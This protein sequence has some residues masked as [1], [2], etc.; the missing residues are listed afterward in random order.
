MSSTGSCDI[1]NRPLALAGYL[2]EV[3]NLLLDDGVAA[4]YNWGNHATCNCGFLTRVIT[5]S[6]VEHLTAVTQ[7][8]AMFS[9]AKCG[10]ATWGTLVGCIWN[11]ETAWGSVL[12]ELRKAGLSNEDIH[13]LEYL[14][15][16]E[17]RDPIWAAIKNSYQSAANLS[18]YCQRWSEKI[19]E[20]HASASE[21]AS[22]L[23]TSDV[24]PVGELIAV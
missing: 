8:P 10:E 4:K 7:E 15:H 12:R 13:H 11:P 16:P 1:G 17:L 9:S 23:T 24:I 18:V 22:G 6:T 19:E 20:F 2:K 21:Q 3:V 5:G 14:S